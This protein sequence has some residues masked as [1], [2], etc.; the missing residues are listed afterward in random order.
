M[1][2]Q[3]HRDV[4][5]RI[6]EIHIFEIYHCTY[7]QFYLKRTDANVQNFSCVPNLTTLFRGKIISKTSD[8]QLINK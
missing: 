7:C 5:T 1:L 8:E 2:E 6:W 3:I 4:T